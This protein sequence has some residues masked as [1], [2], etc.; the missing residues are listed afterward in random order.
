MKNKLINKRKTNALL[1]LFGLAV[2]SLLNPTYWSEPIQAKAAIPTYSETIIFPERSYN[3]GSQT[4]TIPNNARNIRAYTNNGSVSTSKSGTQLTINVSGGSYH[5]SGSYYDSTYYSSYA[6]DTR[7]S[8]IDAFPYN[9]YYSNGS[10]TGTLSK[11]GNSYLSSGSYVGAQS[12]TVTQTRTTS[13]G[14][15]TSDLPSSISYN[16]DGYTGTLTKSGSA[17]KILVSGT[18]TPA[19]SKTVS[20]PEFMKKRTDYHYWSGSLW[21]YD[22]TV[23]DPNSEPQT[24]VYNSGGYSGTLT[25]SATDLVK[26][27]L[28]DYPA[29][30]KK[31]QVVRA[32]DYDRYYQFS[33]TV[34]KPATDTRV[35]K[36]EQDYSGTVTKP[37]VDTRIY[38]QKYSGYSYSG[39]YATNYWYQYAVNITYE[40]D[41]I[42]PG[43]N[44]EYDK[45]AGVIRASATDDEYGMQYIQL[46]NGTISYGDSATYAVTSGGTYTFTA[47]DNGGN[48]TSKS[49]ELKSPPISISTEIPNTTWTKRDSY[50]MKINT[51]ASYDEK[52]LVTLFK[53]GLKLKEE[54]TN[55][56][57]Y[58]VIDNGIYQ[59]TVKDGSISSTKTVNISNFDRSAPNLSISYDG[60]TPQD[61]LD[62]VATA[63][64]T[65]SG[66]KQMTL[67]DGS[68]TTGT[69]ARFKTLT[70]GTFE[71][72][73]EDKA[74]NTQKVQTVVD[75]PLL[76]VKKSITG[77]TNVTGYNV[78]SSFT[79]RYT[80]IGQIKNLNTN[81]TTTTNRLMTMVTSNGE[82]K[83]Q[84]NDGGILSDIVSEQV[85]NF[86]RVP[87]NGTLT[88]DSSTPDDGLDIVLN[89]TDD[90][91]GIKQITL[92]DGR[93]VKDTKATFTTTKAGSFSFIIEDEAGNKKTVSQ[94]INKP[95]L[96]VSKSTNVITNA[97]EL[98]IKANFTP[99]YG[100]PGSITN[101]TSGAQTNNKQ[102]EYVITENGTYR[103]QANDGGV[104]SDVV[105]VVV[106]NFDRTPPNATLSYD[107]STPSDGLDINLSAT[108]DYA[109]I[110]SITLPNGS[111]VNTTKANF[112]TT[113]AGLFDFII[114][115]NAG[116]KRIVTATVQK[117]SLN[118]NKA[119]L[120]QTNASNF[121][122]V[123]SFSPKYVTT[124]QIKNLTTGGNSTTN[125]LTYTVSSNGTY[126]F[127]ANDGGVL[128]DIESVVVNNF[129]RTAPTG[130]ISYDGSRP[131]DGLKILVNASDTE[132][133]IKSIT[134]P[135]GIVRNESNV[136][137]L[138]TTIGTYSF[139]IEDMAGNKKTVTATIVKPTLTAV[140]GITAMT[141]VSEYQVTVKTSAP[142]YSN[143]MIV[144]E[145]TR[146]NVFRSTTVAFMV[147]ENGM[148]RF[149]V[150]DGG[151]L[152]DYLDIPITNFDRKKPEIEL[153]L[154]A[155][156]ATTTTVNV[157][158]LDKGDSKN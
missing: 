63:I 89:A 82:Y 116:N 23:Q 133:D 40:A 38:T 53:D 51:N 152:S 115:D 73:L 58:D 102:V 11:D 59:I 138:V 146:D 113:T 43:L 134:L 64:D 33:G 125:T 145:L 126:K 49:I 69:S 137:Y 4:I 9:I 29:K 80:T 114:E 56:M 106:G 27:K 139:I 7:T 141:N 34:T 71:F 60:S 155:K 10:Y 57:M 26:T 83:F 140:K 105:E 24:S 87:P 118:V 103:F 110:K 37:A 86:D 14:G 153:S 17:D 55:E 136:E 20:L 151:I 18:T 2:S 72:L 77:A 75:K 78:E 156:T 129:D 66:V 85:D 93:V 143:D 5:R 122:L 99:Q 15:T 154:K 108:D 13:S 95:N 50:W 22:H 25:R 41:L 128:S 42:A 127:Q 100:S 150:N 84:A 6:T 149:Q 144:K 98:I 30:P 45:D 131:D 1:V 109:G 32:L 135:N 88:L 31:G 121:N 119:V 124:G 8:S 76:T 104:L 117:P 16:T 3:S 142:R 48:S 46:P 147:K 35:Y 61:G 52:P 130:I 28:Y 107:G 74:G 79:P 67:P 97:P 81:I 148:Y 158:I 92:P 96:L 39:G 19:H 36:Y 157:K 54:Q 90:S 91:S 132:S 123:A 112:K 44:L 21:L 101:L 65:Q 47:V 62:I 94:T 111:V 70:E 12:K 120:S 68:V